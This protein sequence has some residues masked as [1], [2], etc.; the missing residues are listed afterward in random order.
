MAKIAVDV[1]LL[2]C[3][4]MMDRAIGANR[5]LLKQR[6][7][8][9][10]LD[11]ENGLPHIS[12]AMGCIDGR[13]VADIEKILQAVAESNAPGPLT[14]VGLRTET[15]PSGEEVSVFEIRKTPRIQSLHEAVMRTVAKHF[16]YDVAPDMVL[17]PAVSPSTLSSIRNYPKRS[18]FGNFS[19][20][21]TVGYGRIDEFSSPI[22]FSA[23]Q[24]AL[25]HLGNHC[26]CREV[27]ASV[28]LW[29]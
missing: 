27:L 6:A 11:R 21:I 26:T 19:P 23:T 4:E 15:E 5:E 1:V 20:H 3:D 2:P 29:S 25:C 17:A 8:G 22:E 16:T 12:L 9:I 14:I 7:D 24:L 18:S 13:D 10:I 28:R